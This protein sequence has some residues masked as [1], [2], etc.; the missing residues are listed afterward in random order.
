MITDE[1]KKQLE[2]MANRHLFKEKIFFYNDIKKYVEKEKPSSLLD[3]GCA[4]G[5]LI[6]MLKEDFSTITVIDGYDPGVKQFE[7][8]P[9]RTYDC[10]ISNDVIEHIEPAFLDT[11]LE[12]IDSYFIKSAWIIIACYPA[13]KFLSD[14]R[15][16]H[17]TIQ[18]PDWWVEKI[19]KVMKNSTIKESSVIVKNPDSDILNK[20]TGKV[21]VPKGHQLELRLILEKQ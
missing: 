4:H 1:Y 19:K 3:F 21:L 7:K 2:Q 9:S 16:A 20:K 13:K 17:L 18:Q 6:E 10:L 5:K 15:N 11:T 14:G 12:K 8:I